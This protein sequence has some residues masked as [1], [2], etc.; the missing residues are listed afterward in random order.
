MTKILK[1]L[2]VL[3]SVGGG[4]VIGSQIHLKVFGVYSVQDIL[5]VLAIVVILTW[6]AWK[7]LF[8]AIDRSFPKNGR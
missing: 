7:F 2:T 3:V 5:W 1:V 4:V 6:L 8:P